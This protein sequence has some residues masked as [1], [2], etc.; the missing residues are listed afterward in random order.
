MRLDQAMTLLRGLSSREIRELI[1]ARL[2][3][4]DVDNFDALLQNVSH[5][6]LLLVSA[7][8]LMRRGALPP[9]PRGEL[10]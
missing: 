10:R 7:R 5:D 2:A 8:A 4:G 3:P 6:V 9:L 1:R